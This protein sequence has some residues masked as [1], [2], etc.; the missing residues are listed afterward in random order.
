MTS[1][2]QVVAQP[3]LPQCNNFVVTEEKQLNICEIL[4]FS[5]IPEEENKAVMETNCSEIYM[6]GTGRIIRSE[7]T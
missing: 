1:R 2:C 7:S 4:W 6:L 5:I 3:R